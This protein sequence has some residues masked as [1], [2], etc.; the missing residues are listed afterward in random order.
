MSGQWSLPHY[1]MDSVLSKILTWA[2]VFPIICHGQGYIP[3]YAIVKVKVKVKVVVKVVVMVVVAVGK[4]QT[5][6]KK[7]RTRET[8]NLSTDADKWTDTILCWLRDLSF[9]FK[10]SKFIIELELCPCIVLAV[11]V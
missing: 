2:V 9:F 10:Y 11:S 4:R 3:Y 1:G 6:I 7:S 5:T 8:E